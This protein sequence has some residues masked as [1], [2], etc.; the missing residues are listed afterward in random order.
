MDLYQAKQYLAGMG[1]S[2]PDFEIEDIIAEIDEK[3]ECLESNYPDYVI[4]RI[5]RYLLAMIASV[6]ISQYISNRGLSGGLYQGFTYK[7]ANDLYN[8]QLALLKSIDTSGCVDSVIPSS[9]FK[10]AKAFIMTVTGG[11]DE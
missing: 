8:G 2:I 9:P 5:Y 1:L 11:C 6:Q 3:K 10:K 4:R 7:G